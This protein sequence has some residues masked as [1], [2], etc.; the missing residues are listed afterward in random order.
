MMK[1]GEMMHSFRIFL[2]LH[3]LTLP[4]P[5]QKVPCWVTLRKTPSR[6]TSCFLLSSFDTLRVTL[7][8]KFSWNV[9]NLKSLRGSSRKLRESL[10]VLLNIVD[11]NNHDVWPKPAVSEKVELQKK[12]LVLEPLSEHSSKFKRCL[13]VLVHLT[14]SR[15]WNQ[16]FNRIFKLSSHCLFPKYTTEIWLSPLSFG[17]WMLDNRCKRLLLKVLR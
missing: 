5:W 4:L 16:I 7:D 10:T 14:G 2:L 12:T 9:Q 13:L 3:R 6:G 8:A 1:P 17:S 11:A 15:T